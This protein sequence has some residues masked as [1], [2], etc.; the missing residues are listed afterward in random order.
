MRV[1]ITEQTRTY[2]NYQIHDLAKDAE[3]DGELALHLVHIQAPVEVLDGEPAAPPQPPASTDT[4]SGGGP[5]SDGEPQDEEPPVD[6]TIDTLMTWVGDSPERAAAAL[7]A[8]QAKDSPRVTA[9]KHLT[10]LVEAG[11]ET[12]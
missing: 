12:E 5:A 11:T 3:V 8:E 2:W 9:V 6:G 7:A 10:A 4:D 1:R